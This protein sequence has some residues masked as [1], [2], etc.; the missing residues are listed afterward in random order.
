MKCYFLAVVCSELLIEMQSGSCYVAVVEWPTRPVNRLS[1]AGFIQVFFFVLFFKVTDM[2]A[3]YFPPICLSLPFR[4]GHLFVCVSCF[5][6][7][8][9]KVGTAVGFLKPQTGRMEEI[10]IV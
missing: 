4:Q 6:F 9:R 7:E 3:H 5:L 2:K 1:A 8:E 10:L